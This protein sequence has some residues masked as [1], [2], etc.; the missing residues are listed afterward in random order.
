[1][2]PWLS[3]Y[4]DKTSAELLL[5]GFSEG[6]RLGYEGP[7]VPRESPNLKSVDLDPGAIRTKLNKEIELGRIAGPFKSRPLDRL[8][9][10]PIGLIPKSEPGKMRLIQHLSYP[11]GDSVNDGIVKSY[12]DVSYASFDVAV[13]LVASIGPGAWMAKADIK[14][15]FR[16]L[17]MHPQDFELLGMKVGDDYFVDK[18]LPMGASCSP[19]L[20]EKF[21]TFI[22]WVTKQQSNSQMVTHYADDFLLLGGKGGGKGSCSSL[23]SAFKGVCSEFGVPLAEEKSVGP[24]T[25]LVYLGLEINSVTQE[26][27][28]PQEK[29]VKI[30]AKVDRAIHS[31]MLSLRELQSLIGSLSFVCKA[32]SPGRTF[33]RRLINLTCGVKKQGHKISMTTGAKA[34]LNMWLVFLKKFN[35]VAIIPDQRWIEDSELELFTDASGSIGFAGFFQG[36]WFQEVW[37]EDYGRSHSITL[38]EFFPVVVAVV[39]WGHQLVG[40]RII[41]RSDNEAVVAII[42]KQTS[43]CPYVMK[44]LRFLVLQCM[45]FNLHLCARHISGKSNNVADALSRFQMARFREVAPQADALG[46]P[47]PV[48]LWT[49]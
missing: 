42:N 33:L 23:V 16:L 47:V 24:C 9:V 44:L 30:V 21:S 32:I 28:V 29:V 20:F 3:K 35:G 4:P 46:T 34:D 22:E 2:L 5:K 27:S 7:R 43:R 38:L 10:S 36:R 45:K 31:P 49:L 19:A 26:V 15:A 25:K 48:F 40:K 17:P 41:L 14:S 11:E 8:R 12:C 39:L 6:F 13:G 37:P 18:A 1:M